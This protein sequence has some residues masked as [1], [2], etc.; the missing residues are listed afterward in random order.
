MLA[1]DRALGPLVRRPDRTPVRHDRPRQRTDRMTT[2]TRPGTDGAP[3]GDCATGA[4]YA[5]SDYG[6]TVFSGGRLRRPDGCSPE[7]GHGR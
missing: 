6:A 3:A 2:Y 1:A 5:V 4:D 7:L